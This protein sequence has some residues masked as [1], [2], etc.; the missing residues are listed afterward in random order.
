MLNGL[1]CL[2]LVLL[3]L[4]VLARERART[5]GVLRAVG[6]SMRHTVALLAGAGVTLIAVA[7]PLGWALERWVFAPFVSRVVDRYGVLPLA[8]S[9]RDLVARRRRRSRCGRSQRR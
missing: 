2:A 8:P 6:G 9:L 4:V 1:G 5:I 3:A 7:L